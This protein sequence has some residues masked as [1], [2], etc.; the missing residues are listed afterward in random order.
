MTADTITCPGEGKHVWKQL[1]LTKL[2]GCWYCRRFEAVAFQCEH[3]GSRAVRWCTV[4]GAYCI[5]PEPQA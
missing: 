1:N 4:C 2:F 3:G 5:A